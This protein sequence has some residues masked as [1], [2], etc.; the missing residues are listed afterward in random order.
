M[1]NKL[2]L[3]IFFSLLLA[4]CSQQ[5]D[6]DYLIGGNWVATAGYKG[7]EAKGEP[8]CHFFEEGLE[9]K[10]EDIVYN[11]SFDEDF[12]YYL[13]DQNKVTEISFESPNLGTYIFKV[14]VISENEMGFE[15]IGLTEKKSCYLER[16]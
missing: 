9:F 11:T 7:G 5:A 10:T 8:D 13:F 16:K 14:H 1:R 2:L 3:I 15:G 4:S 12:N 6:A